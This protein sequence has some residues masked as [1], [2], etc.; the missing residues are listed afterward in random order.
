MIWKPLGKIRSFC[1]SEP[2]IFPSQT[3]CWHYKSCSCFAFSIILGV[4]IPYCLSCF[5]PIFL[6]FSSICSLL[7]SIAFV[8]SLWPTVLTHSSVHHQSISICSL[9]CG[10]SWDWPVSY[11]W[12]CTFFVLLRLALPYMFL[13]LNLAGS[14]SYNT[15]ILGLLSF[16]PNIKNVCIHT[17][18]WII[19]LM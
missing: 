3:S 10:F 16:C 17:H 13:S 15:V 11:L 19:K 2:M 12:L 14:H 8:Y 5:C 4:L 7:I 9:D 1:G 18:T 6:L